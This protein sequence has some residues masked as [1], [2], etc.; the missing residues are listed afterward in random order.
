MIRVNR[1]RYYQKTK[2]EQ[3]NKLLENLVKD[4]TKMK[5]RIEKKAVE[6]TQQN[7]QSVEYQK[8]VAENKKLIEEL[9]K[10]KGVKKE[11]K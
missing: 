2:D 5:I 6:S 11:K 3:I 4:L 1:S 9:Q 10:F 8:I 7:Y